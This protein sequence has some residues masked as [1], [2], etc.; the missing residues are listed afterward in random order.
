M[1]CV[2]AE[3]EIGDIMTGEQII[4]QGTNWQ[5]VVDATGAIILQ[6]QSNKFAANYYIGTSAP[7]S[8]HGMVLRALNEHTPLIEAGEALYLRARS[9]DVS[10]T[11]CQ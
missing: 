8:E 1:L 11:W 7:T 6:N 10:I 2:F 4:T 9:G 3:N 5:E